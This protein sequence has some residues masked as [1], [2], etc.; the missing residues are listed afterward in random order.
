MLGKACVRVCVGVWVCVYGCLHV[1]ERARGGECNEEE[2]R[3]LRVFVC[4]C[5]CSVSRKKNDLFTKC[6]CGP[7]TYV[8]QKAA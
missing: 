3:C 6:V 4:V 2:G 1:K 5:W 8:L 7:L